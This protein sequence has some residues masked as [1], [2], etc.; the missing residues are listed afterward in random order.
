[1]SLAGRPSLGPGVTCCGPGNA[2]RFAC[3]YGIIVQFILGFG[4]QDS[5]A[6]SFAGHAAGLLSPLPRG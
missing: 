2:K 4:L 1:M 6:G 5:V 3:A